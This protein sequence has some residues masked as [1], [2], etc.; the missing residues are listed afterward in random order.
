M[1]AEQ[2]WNDFAAL[3]EEGQKQVTELMRWLRL[4][5]EKAAAKRSALQDEPFVGMWKDRDDLQD[6]SEWVRQLREKEWS[7]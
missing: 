2:L 6:S 4:S 1:Q 5:K 7:R 3:S